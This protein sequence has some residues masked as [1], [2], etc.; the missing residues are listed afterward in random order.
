MNQQG[1]IPLPQGGLGN[2]IFINIAGYV[3]S[4]HLKC[5]LYLFNNT[6]C[7]NSHS[8]KEYKYNIFKYLGTH[9]NQMFN[10]NLSN[11]SY[12]NL[13]IFQGFEPWSLESIKPGL[14]LQSY[15]QYYPPL[16]KFEF[17]IREILLKGLLDYKL[18]LLEKY[19]EKDLEK[20]A[21]LHVRRG[22]YLVFS[23]RHFVQPIQYYK[24]C[25][26]IFGKSVRKIYLLSDDI[27]WVKSQ[28]LFNDRNFFEPFECEDELTSLTFMS[29]CK[30]GAICANSTFSWWGAFLGSYEKRSPIFVPEKWMLTTS[31]IKLFPKEWNIIKES[32]FN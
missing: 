7:N 23:D 3:M 30:S 24:H 25:L 4:L 14:I 8:T 21:F 27:E 6:N 17:E 5:P 18:Q 32:D 12:H 19:N 22:D 13:N 15:Y 9:I 29:M 16:E 2:Q 20:S 28:E 11:Y 26:N 10:Y 1:I 31:E